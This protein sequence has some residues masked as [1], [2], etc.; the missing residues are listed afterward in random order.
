MPLLRQHR[1]RRSTA[2]FI[3]H[4]QRSRIRNLSECALARTRPFD[5]GDDPDSRAAEPRHRIDG[6]IDVLTAFLQAFQ[7]NATLTD[8]EI[9]PD[10]GKDVV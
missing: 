6:W 4:R 7:R 5:L 1:N 3:F 8:R 10:S 9:L 2:G